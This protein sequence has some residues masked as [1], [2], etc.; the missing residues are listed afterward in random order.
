[1]RLRI[2]TVNVQNGEGDSRRMAVLKRGLRELDPDIVALQEVLQGGEHR[3]LQELLE[4]TDLCGTHQAKAMQ[5]TPP[6]AERYGGSAVATRWPHRVVEVIDSRSIGANDVPWCTLGALVH[7][8]SLGEL[9]FI[10]AT[11][12]WRLDAEAAREQQAIA[13]SDLDA[14]QR[15]DL[16]TIIAG[17]FNATTMRWPTSSR[18]KL[19]VA[20]RVFDFSFGGRKK[21]RAVSIDYP[22]S[23]GA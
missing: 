18:T 13:L 11:S 14:R 19:C 16:P 23:G 17:D 20:L 3:Q 21:Q 10:A 9:L 4:G 6:F 2:L 12:S 15:K 7:L 5:Y 8:P 22:R 1:M